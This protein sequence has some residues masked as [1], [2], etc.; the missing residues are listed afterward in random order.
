[1][2]WVYCP[3]GV[4]A[5]FGMAIELREHLNPKHPFEH[6]GPA[7]IVFDVGLAAPRGAYLT[8][9]ASAV[10]GGIVIGVTELVVGW[11]IA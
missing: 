5:V 9:T 4:G 7:Q 3:L 10:I 8:I 2:I 1:M 11:Q 6:N